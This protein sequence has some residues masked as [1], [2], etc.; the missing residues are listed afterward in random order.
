MKTWLKSG[1]IAVVSLF[2]LYI[3]VMIFGAR[4][5]CE[6]NTVE[7]IHC[8]NMQIFQTFFFPIHSTAFGMGTLIIF[9]ITFGISA[10]IGWIIEKI[11]N[12]K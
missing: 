11:K 5:V 6:F 7:N 2:L 1:V 12:K 8:T 3:F 4:D 10:S 9:L